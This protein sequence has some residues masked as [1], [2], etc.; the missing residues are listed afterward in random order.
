MALSEYAPG[1]DMRAGCNRRE[2][3]AALQRTASTEKQVD[4]G[5]LLWF[6]LMA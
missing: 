2:R 4:V 6:Y 3:L 5:E 1:C